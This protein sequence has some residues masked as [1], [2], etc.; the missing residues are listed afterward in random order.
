MTPAPASAHDPRDLP[1]KNNSQP[2]GL[3]TS[4]PTVADAFDLGTLKL[5][6]SVDVEYVTKAAGELEIVS[7]VM[8]GEP[9]VEP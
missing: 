2:V 7:I 4:G 3:A 8:R 5:L 9:E 1:T 6:R